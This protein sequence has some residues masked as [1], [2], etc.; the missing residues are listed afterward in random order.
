MKGCQVLVL[1]KSGHL[2]GVGEIGELYMRSHFLAKVRNSSSTSL[3]IVLT[4]VRVMWVSTMRRR[5]SSCQIR[6]LPRSR[7]A[8]I[9]RAT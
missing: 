1:N 6:L 9:V 3:F 4:S 5:P 8:C 7:T 2:G